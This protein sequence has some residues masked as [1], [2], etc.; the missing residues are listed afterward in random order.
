M[1]ATLLKWNAGGPRDV[2]SRKIDHIA[3]YTEFN[4]QAASVVSDIESTLLHRLYVH[5]EAQIPLG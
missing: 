2:V 4:H 5:D 1:T 3:L